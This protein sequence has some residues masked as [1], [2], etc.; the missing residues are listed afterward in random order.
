MNSIKENIKNK[1]YVKKGFT[2]IELMLVV[3]IIGI[4]TSVQAVVMLKYMKIHRQEINSIREAFYIN[5]AF[6]IIQHEIDNEGY[7]KIKNNNVI[8]ITRKNGGGFNY[9][10][11]N[12]NSDIIVSYYSEYYS[13]TN[14][15]LKNVKNF[16]VEKDRH[17]LYVSI[18]TKKGNVYR[19]CFPLK[20][21]EDQK[22]SS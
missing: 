7:V 19:R 12:R 8:V 21:E 9:I 4:I 5:E 3:S 11:T 16:K 13:T 17:V 14:N 18:E 15:I 22:G 20:R 2:L 1:I 6:T 10:R